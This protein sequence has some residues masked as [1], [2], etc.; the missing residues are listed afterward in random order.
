MRQI[1]GDI[2]RRKMSD[3]GAIGI[4]SMREIAKIEYK[5]NIGKPLLPGIIGYLTP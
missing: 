3:N 2:A 1:Y 5:R 4:Q